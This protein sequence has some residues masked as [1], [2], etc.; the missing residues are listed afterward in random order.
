MGKPS[1]TRTFW[2]AEYVEVGLLREGEEK[3]VEFFLP[4]N[5]GCC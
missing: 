4:G 1:T 2:A 3:I 5:F